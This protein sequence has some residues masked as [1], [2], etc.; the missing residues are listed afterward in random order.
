MTLRN[1]STTICGV[2]ANGNGGCGGGIDAFITIY[3]LQ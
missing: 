2:N 1:L 3:A